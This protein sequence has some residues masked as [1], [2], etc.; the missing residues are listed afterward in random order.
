MRVEVD[1]DVWRNPNAFNQLLQLMQRAERG[2]HTIR[3]LNGSPRPLFSEAFFQNHVG[4]AKH[5]SFQR[6]LGASR[7]NPSP[8]VKAVAQN[9]SSFSRHE[10]GF[11]LGPADLGN[12]AE[13]RLEILLEN[14]TD[15]LLIQWAA[16][17]ALDAGFPVLT[18]AINDSW[19]EPNGRGGS[20]EVLKLVDAPECKRYLAVID[21]DRE[22]WGD[23]LVGTPKQIEDG[24]MN[25]CVPVFVLAGRELES[26]LPLSFWELVVGS[27]RTSR[28]PANRAK[29]NQIWG[30]LNSYLEKNEVDLRR[31]HG[32][33]TFEDVKNQVETSA[34]RKMTQ[35]SLRSLLNIHEQLSFEDRAVDDLKAR[36]GKHRAPTVVEAAENDIDNYSSIDIK[37]L[38]R[39][40]LLQV[41]ALIVE[42]L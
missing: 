21:S 27:T 24:G 39:A 19:V 15:W 42:W 5:M 36:F 2:Q 22:H 40:D 28:P 17:V 41:A 37:P 33:K 1:I 10:N 8:A 14:R 18:S 23:P 9:D 31:N 34:T 30:K 7:N 3:V 35:S 13:E 16:K 38:L 20:G 26:Y 6:L 12:W 25:S 4:S 32:S 11:D 29:E